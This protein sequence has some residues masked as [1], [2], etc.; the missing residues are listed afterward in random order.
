M[1]NKNILWYSKARYKLIKEYKQDYKLMAGLIASTSVRFSITRNI[2]T[3]RKIYDE[4]IENK[5]AFLLYIELYPQEFM[6]RFKIFLAHYCNIVSTLKHDF[7]KRKKLVLSGQKVSSF[8]ANLTGDYYRVTIDIWILRYFK[9]KKYFVNGSEYKNYS[10]IIS[11]RAK[12]LNLFPCQL[13]ADIWNK[14]REKWGFKPM[15]LHEAI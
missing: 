11:N 7:T 5:E 14:V 6:K 12:K 3:A 2:N 8:Y 4:Y 10:N 9:H 15:F 1:S 13:Q